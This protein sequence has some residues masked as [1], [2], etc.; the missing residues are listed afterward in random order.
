LQELDSGI[1][2]ALHHP[3][4]GKESQ[5]GKLDKNVG[6]GRGGL[7]AGWWWQVG[8]VPQMFNGLAEVLLRVV[9]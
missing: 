7:L 2:N 5:Q 1:K 3:H 6:S 4:Q 8:G 9:D